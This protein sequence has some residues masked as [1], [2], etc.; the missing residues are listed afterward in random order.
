MQETLQ[1]I[2][3]I[4]ERVRNMP[5]DSTRMMVI[6]GAVLAFGLLN[7]ILGYRLLRFWVMLFGFGIGAGT[8]FFLAEELE[9]QR[10]V[11]YLAVML[12][13]G[14]VVA[15][16]A[17]LIYR[18]GIFLLGGGTALVVS[19]YV[20]HPTSSATFFLCILIGVVIGS[21]AIRFEK[22]VI[23]VVTSLLG[24]VL[25]G[26]CLAKLLR[27]E[28]FPAG[29][30]AGAAA[31]LL[32]MLIQFLTNRTEEEDSEEV[33]PEE[34]TLYGDGLDHYDPYTGEPLDEEREEHKKGRKRT[35]D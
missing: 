5:A 1:R 18:A 4:L 33:D 34:K 32:G 13:L 15:V 29:F 20:I 24:G 21:L 25:F 19:I 12:G 17:F 23:I 11:L 6:F 22:E 27:M 28:E 7:C 3:A 9:L 26:F 35:N 14:I 16:V 30:L 2:L 31:A 8:G 10:S